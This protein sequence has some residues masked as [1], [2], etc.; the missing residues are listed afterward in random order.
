MVLDDCDLAARNGGLCRDRRQ[1]PYA[2]EHSEY[3]AD[4][5]AY[6]FSSPA[7][8]PARS[9]QGLSAFR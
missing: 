2:K 7:P 5:C 4:Q 3:T 6:E 8:M 1:A 9:L